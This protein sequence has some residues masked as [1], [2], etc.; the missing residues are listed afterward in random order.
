M[1]SCCLDQLLDT[2]VIEQELVYSRYC[3][4]EVVSVIYR[5]LHMLTQATKYFLGLV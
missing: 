1:I 4:D 5:A 3:V 2:A